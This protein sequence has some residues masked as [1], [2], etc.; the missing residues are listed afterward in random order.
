LLALVVLALQKQVQLEAMAPIR[1]SILLEIH[2]VMFGQLV[3]VEA[4]LLVYLVLLAAQAAEEE[5]AL[6][7]HLL[8]LK[9]V[10]L[11][12]LVVIHPLKEMRDQLVVD[13][14]VVVVE[15]EL[16]VLVDQ[17]VVKWEA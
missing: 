15:V 13:N 14:T 17:Q 16:A 4:A 11:V 3:E 2:Q 10:V 5:A 8:T 6:V 12:T 7:E 9:V 1:V